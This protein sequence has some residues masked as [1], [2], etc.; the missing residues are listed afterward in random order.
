MLQRYDMI[1][2]GYAY[3]RYPAREENP[4]QVRR[5]LTAARWP[6]GL[7]RALVDH[8]FPELAPAPELRLARFDHRID[9][10]VY[11]R[12]YG[13]SLSEPRRQA[14]LVML[15]VLARQNDLLLLSLRRDF[16]ASHLQ[17]IK[18][19]LNARPAEVALP[20]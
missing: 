9:E 5:V 8:W 19:L 7:S 11:L 1:L 16:G 13:E 2:I 12:L 4:G 18:R 3:D 20:S 6:R 14:A 17:V 15:Q 10:A